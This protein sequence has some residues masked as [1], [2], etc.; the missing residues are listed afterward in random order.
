VI[1]FQLLHVAK[2]TEHVD[3]EK[4]LIEGVNATRS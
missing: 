4:K 2:F 1:D 3:P